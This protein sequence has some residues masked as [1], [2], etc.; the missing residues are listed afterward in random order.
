MINSGKFTGGKWVEEAIANADSISI[1]RRTSSHFDVLLLTIRSLSG[2]RAVASNSLQLLDLQID[3]CSADS[4][5]HRV[6]IVFYQ[7]TNRSDDEILKGKWAIGA[8]S[9]VSSSLNVLST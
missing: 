6:Y 9:T 1:Q 5:T 8:Q 2:L 3:Y 7:S 4:S